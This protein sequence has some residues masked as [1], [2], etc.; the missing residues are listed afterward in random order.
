MDALLLMVNAIGWTLIHSLWLG[1]IA[2]LAYALPAARCLG[3]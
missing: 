2:A 1:A 3:D